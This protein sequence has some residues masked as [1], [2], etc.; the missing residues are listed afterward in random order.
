IMASRANNGKEVVVSDK[1]LKGLRKGTKG[2]KSSTIKSP[3]ARR[4]R[5]NALEEHGLK[6]FNAEKEAK[7]AQENWIDEGRLALEFPTICNTVSEMGLGY[8]LAKPEV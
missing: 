5:A 1:G 6:W 3:P 7:Y 4:F 2:S 8:V